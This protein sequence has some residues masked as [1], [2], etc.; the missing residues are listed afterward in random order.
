MKDKSIFIAVALDC[1][2]AIN[3]YIEGYTAEDFHSERKTQDAGY[4]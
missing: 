1:I 3:F 4:S 2:K